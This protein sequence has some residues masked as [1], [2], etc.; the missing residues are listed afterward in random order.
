MI[1]SVQVQWERIIL[2]L[3]KMPASGTHVSVKFVLS[4]E[5]NIASVISVDG[6]ANEAAT[7]ACVSAI[8]ERAPYG[9][10]PAAMKATLGDKQE[11][12]FNFY[13]Q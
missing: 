8:T 6:T 4:P 5:G 1:D 10:W 9:A 3:S 13:Y 7:R 12:T 2:N 11:M